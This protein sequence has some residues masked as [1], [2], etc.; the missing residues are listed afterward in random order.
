MARAGTLPD[1]LYQKEVQVG[2][3]VSFQWTSLLYRDNH[4]NLRNFKVLQNEANPNNSLKANRIKKAWYLDWHQTFTKRK[5]ALARGAPAN[6]WG[7]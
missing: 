5:L 3:K 2:G 6:S 4:T 7:S 1:Y